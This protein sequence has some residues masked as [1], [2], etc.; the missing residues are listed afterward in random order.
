MKIGELAKRSRLSA[1]TIRYYERIGLLPYAHRDR[2]SQRDYDA[3]ILAW[4]EFIG[5]LKT[6]GMPIR[7]M[8]RYAVL[9][10]QGTGTEADRRELLEQHR[11]RVRAQVTELSAC[12]LVLDAKIGG[13]ADAEKRIKNDDAIPPRNPRKPIGARTA[14]A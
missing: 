5:R 2:S 14:R 11:E 4:I 13:Y 6:T 3:S 10:E 9:R 7:E 12:L 1:H 8:L